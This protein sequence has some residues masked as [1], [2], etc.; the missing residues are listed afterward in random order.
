METFFKKNS[1]LS[2][3]IVINIAIFLFLQLSGIITTLF[4]ASID[5]IE[6]LG[7]PSS[8][9]NLPTRFWTVITYMFV[10]YNFLHILFNMLWLY[11]FGKIFLILFNSKQLGGLYILGG[12]AGAIL[13]I[14]AYNVFPYFRNMENTNYL[15]GASASVMSIVFGSAFYKKDFEINLLFLG[16]IKIIYLAIFSLILDIL[17]VTSTNAGGH[18]AHIGGA[19]TGI[20]F[21]YYIKKGKDITDWLNTLI[22]KTVDMFK[23][24]SVKMTVNYNQRVGSEYEYNERKNKENKEIDKILDKIKKSGYSSLT[25]E[26]KKKLFDASKK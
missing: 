4:N 24:E 1:I 5:S 14:L 26:E 22:D 7:F 19:L 21:S 15:M 23:K 18:I 9:G 16:R 25:S 11:W 17:A 6:Y 3:L 12:I 8:F 10:H 2:K 13:F 20:T